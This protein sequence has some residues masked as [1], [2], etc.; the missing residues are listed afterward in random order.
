MG[1]LG[2]VAVMAVLFVVLPFG[3]QAVE[4]YTDWLWFHEVGFPGVFGTIL[5]TKALLGLVAGAVAFLVL[6]ANVLA[7]RRG[8][9]PSLVDLDDGETLPQLPSWSL[10]EPLYRR[11]RLPACLVIAF[12]LSGNG[13][14]LWETVIRYRNAGTFGVTD[15]LFGR[16]VGFYVF[17]YPLLV[18]VFQFLTLV[19]S[20]TL[21]AVAAIYVLSR[22]IRLTPAGLVADPWAKGHLLALGAAFLVVKA[23]GYSLDAF[24]LL[25]SGGGASF[26][27]SYTDVNATLPAL[28]VMI[29]LAGLGAVLL[30]FQMS[31]P[32]FLFAL[33][34]I[35]L[36]LGGGLLGLTAYPAVVQRLRVAPNEI[37]AERPYIERSIAATNRAY[38]LDRIE[39]R[40]F[41][42]EENLSAAVLRTN[43]TTI[44]NIR[45]WEHR[46]ALD[47]YGQLQ[48]IRPYYKFVD[49]DND[50]YQLD[51]ESRQVM[52]SV[53][54]LSHAHLPSRIWINEHLVYTHGYGAVVGPVNR[55]T[56]EGLPEFFVKD[57]PPAVTGSLQITRPEVY[58]GEVANA[59]VLVKMRAPELNYPQ[60]DQ[61]V[62]TTYAGAGGVSIGSLWRR[63][64]FAAR[65]AEVKML[66]SDDFTPESR[67]LYHRQIAERVQKIAPFLRV[68]RDPY[69]VI[70]AAGRIVWLVDTYT[71]TDYFPY[72]HRT[73][74]LGNYIRNPVKATVDAYD[75][76]V[77]LYLVE[78]DE[79]LIAAYARAF[80]GLFQ[81]FAAMPEDLRAHTRYPQD[82][83]G[84][85]ARMYAQFHM[86]DPQ[87][88]YNR[89]D[90]WTVPVRKAEGRD[91]EMEPYYTIMRLPGEKREEFILLLPFTPVRR[92]NMIAWLAARSDPPHY[93]KLV[94]YEF[95]KGKLV[96]GPRQVEARIDQ[97][98]FIS[99]QLS[100]WGQAGS[101]VIR[102]G[103]LAIPIEESL[104][105]VQPLYLAAER[106]RLPELKRVIVAYGN[107]IAMD[108]T[109]EASLQQ[110]FGMGGP[111]VARG[112]PAAGQ[113]AAAG[114][115]AAG[116]V[117]PR[118]A[119]EALE[120]F[121]RARERFGRGDFTGF[122]DD[123]KKLEETLRRLQTESRR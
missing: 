46:P 79:P 94:L 102:G 67:I 15:P 26:G 95:P 34:G 108:E 71:T 10:V 69:P 19:I 61:N 120:H 45:L 77:A 115:P 68:D 42:A 98:A 62:Y 35:G 1:R 78:P 107:R 117:H 57:I 47:S 100:L 13:T 51:G 3:R 112:A 50:R 30:L 40:P 58:Y 22:G 2:V 99:Q 110:L 86:L 87:V 116:G 91:A 82:L 48:E 29:G 44:K 59:Y 76:T 37:V 97:D 70:T 8:L 27:A 18:G 105:Y 74:G 38:G 63:L 7:T 89:E 96:F 36:W 53:R 104:L 93:G 81:P 31:R 17:T 101:Q 11:F 123:L 88:F 43:D 109:L 122:A 113:P 65:F 114:A 92:D 28:Y 33:I 14:A 75:G 25:F 64:A 54:E 55:V 80:P 66:L 6:Y 60:G 73:A 24:G 56:R 111:A 90:L 84:I 20:V 118:L 72:S 85:Q 52:L 121:T 9:G 23:W 83:F 4:L 49:V 41:P 5:S 106:G 12:M 103:L 21:A 16:D 39:S 32:G 119:A